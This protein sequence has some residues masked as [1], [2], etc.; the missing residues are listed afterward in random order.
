MDWVRGPVIGR[1]STAT[2]SLAASRSGGE[3][4]AVKSAKLPQSHFLRREQHFLSSIT[5]PYIVSYRGCC[6]SREGSR[7]LYNLFLEYVPGGTLSD[8]IRQ[9]GNR[10][11]DES[12]IAT[13]TRQ[14][15]LGLEYLHSIG[16]V[17]C[18]IKGSNIL[19]GQSGAKIADLGCARRVAAPRHSTNKHCS[20]PRDHSQA[21][22]AGTPV[23]MAPEVARGEEQG[24]AAD[25]WSLGC[26]I[27][28]MATGKSGWPNKAVGGDD[29]VTVLYQIAYS[30]QVPQI[31]CVLSEE[32]KDF[33][34][35]CLTR[36][37]K[38]R[39]TASQLLR[40]PFIIK[41]ASCGNNI[42]GGQ[43]LG[44]VTTSP[45]S[46]LDQ[47]IWNSVEDL[48]QSL[49]QDPILLTDCS[50]IL[51]AADRRIME[52]SGSSV[53]PRWKFDEGWISVRDGGFNN[54]IIDAPIR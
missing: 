18:D 24:C 54:S 45:T 4:F 51:P 14:I 29:P 36:D 5:S 32:A 2:V 12:M 11:E 38:E 39:W 43:D 44:S 48:S 31:P 6:I 7:D 9:R 8:A 49:N 26:T 23:F 1:G 19:I 17:H 10:L 25:I 46:T 3:I 47:G 13:Y 35:K 28:E 33:L 40:H 34:T 37:P 21:P 41:F 53:S 42:I 52:L 16:V 27:I 30:D 22:M 20:R 50:L 15:L